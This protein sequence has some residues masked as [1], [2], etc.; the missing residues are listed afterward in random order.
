MSPDSLV[1]HPLSSRS[2]FLPGSKKEKNA[3]S[4]QGERAGDD[5]R[6]ASFELISRFVSTTVS[7]GLE[8]SQ[9]IRLIAFRLRRGKLATGQPLTKF[10]EPKGTLRLRS[11]RRIVPPRSFANNWA[12]MS[13]FASMDLNFKEAMN[14]VRGGQKLQSAFAQAL[15]R[16]EKMALS[17]QVPVLLRRAGK[18]MRGNFHVR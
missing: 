1:R 9:E 11:G 16:G 10:A 7:D 2:I 6:I 4:S 12:N 14:N 8:V 5:P 3:S 13:G 15:T 17:K 18:H